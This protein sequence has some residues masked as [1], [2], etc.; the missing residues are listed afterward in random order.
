MSQQLQRGAACTLQV[1]EDQ[2]ERRARGCRAHPAR[3][4]VEQPIALG[5]RIGLKRSRAPGQSIGDGGQEPR[6]LAGKPAEQTWQFVIAGGGDELRQRFDERLIRAT[7][8]LI[9]VTAQHD[10]SVVARQRGHLVQ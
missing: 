8:A 10:G 3:H 9:T 2:H 5:V 7:R 4:G 1:V 6:Q